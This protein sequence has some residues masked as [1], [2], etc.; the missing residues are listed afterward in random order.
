MILQRVAASLR[1]KDWS[2]ALLEFLIVVVGI[3]VGLQ[4]DDWN[5]QRKD[6]KDEAAFLASLHVDTGDPELDQS[7]SGYVDV[8]VGWNYSKLMRVQ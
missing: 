4:V 3:F 5:Q 8:I 6:R 1:N 7:L 2:T